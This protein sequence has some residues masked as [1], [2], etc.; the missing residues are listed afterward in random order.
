M[1]KNNEKKEAKT[2]ANC[3]VACCKYVALEIDCPED[4]VDFA[5][6][7]WYV[8]HKSAKVFVDEAHEWHIEFTTPCQYLRKDN[9][10]EIH[11]ESN[12]NSE[13]KRPNICRDFSS[14][15]CPFHNEY[16]ELFCFETIK[17]VEKYVEEVFKKGEHIV[18][19]E[20]EE[21]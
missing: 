19:E 15:V 3:D 14:D 10:C 5:N 9:K 18:P 17:D 1:D 8:L 4:L 7:K 21:E 16:K 20:N 11:E 6:I 13:I 2:C 12:G